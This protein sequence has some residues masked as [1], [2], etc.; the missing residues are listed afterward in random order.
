MPFHFIDY[1]A[2][3]RRKE[4]EREAQMMTSLALTTRTMAKTDAPLVCWY[5]SHTHSVLHIIMQVIILAKNL[6]G[7]GGGGRAGLMDK[8]ASHP[9][10][11]LSHPELGLKVLPVITN[12]L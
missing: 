6:G 11:P 7:G 10:S 1:Q 3:L 2:L 9:V 5:I 4:R 8:Q 12:N